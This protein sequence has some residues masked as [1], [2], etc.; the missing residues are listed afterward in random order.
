MR[1]FTKFASPAALVV[2]VIVLTAAVGLEKEEAGTVTRLQGSAI[3]IQD[4]NPR[5]LQLG[6]KINLGDI[7]S[8]GP[9]SRLELRMIDDGIFTLGARTN[10]VVM[11]YEF[12][13]KIGGSAVMRLMSGALNAVSGKL[14]QIS[15]TSFRVETELATIGIRG[16]AFWAGSVD[17]KNFEV[18]MWNGKGVTIKNSAGNSEITKP[19]DGVLVKGAGI[20]PDQPVNWEKQKLDAALATVQFTGSPPMS[21]TPR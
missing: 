2:A 19:N 17:G 21:S 6:S 10:F 3:A 16:T 13:D 15:P 8:T 20:E 7:I 12:K 11:E 4:A 18:V 14:A 9:E 5:V 1:K